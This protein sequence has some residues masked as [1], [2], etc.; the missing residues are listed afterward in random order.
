MN[1]FKSINSA[2]NQINALGTYLNQSSFN[3]NADH[4]TDLIRQCTYAE[5]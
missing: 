5:E 3:S 1:L 2:V 4:I